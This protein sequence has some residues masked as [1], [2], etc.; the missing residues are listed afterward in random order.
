MYDQVRPDGEV[1]DSA[2]GYFLQNSLLV[3]KWTSHRGNVVGD[4]IFQLVLPAKLRQSVLKIA[5]NESG[6]SGVKKTYDRLLRHFFLALFKKR[7]FL[8]Y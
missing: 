1:E 5:H 3:R 8:I 2:Y 4:P 6:H 7:C